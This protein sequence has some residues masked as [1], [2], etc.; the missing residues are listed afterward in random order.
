MI[1]YVYEKQQQYKKDKGKN[2]QWIFFSRSRK[3]HKMVTHT[4]TNFIMQQK[5]S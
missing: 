2:L 3:T 5:L 4:Q 1:C